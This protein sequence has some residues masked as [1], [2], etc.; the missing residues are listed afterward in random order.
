LNSKGNIL[1]CPLEWGL[2][3]A[4]RMIPLAGELNAR[5]YSIIIGSGEEH[6]ELFRKEFPGIKCI[7]FTGFKTTYSRLL[8]QYIHI[9]FKLPSLL[10]HSVKEHYVLKKIIREN[11]IDIVISDNRFGLWNRDIVSVYVTHMPRIPFPKL[12]RPLEFTGVLFHKAVI[13]KYSL[14]FIPDMPGK[15]NL[16]GRLSH[17][18]HLPGNVIYT[19][20]LSR[21]MQ[22][23]ETIESKQN[24]EKHVTIILSGPEPQRTMLRER[25]TELFRGHPGSYIFLEGKPLL[26]TQEKPVSGNMLFYNHLPSNL[27][28]HLVK[29]SSSIICRSGYSTLMDL[30]ALNCSALI[31]PTPGQTEQEYLASYLAGKGW[32]S[33]VAQREMNKETCLQPIQPKW[34]DNI[35]KESR[36]LLLKALDKLS[37]YHHKKK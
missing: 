11:D 36:Q 14:C 24:H 13:R 10:Y 25:L 37:D 5:G 21:F 17:D 28:K 20:I 18:V 31:I 29:E 35:V 26:T 32:F 3:H 16:S 12:F 2:G 30:V 22:E 4:A 6:L 8:P 34:P 15:V 1:I 9:M 33:T 27:M 19:G 23:K 7:L